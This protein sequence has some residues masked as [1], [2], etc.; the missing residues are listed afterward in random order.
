MD[1]RAEMALAEMIR[2]VVARELDELYG[3]PT[4]TAT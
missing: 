2:G 3:R 4:S 1:A